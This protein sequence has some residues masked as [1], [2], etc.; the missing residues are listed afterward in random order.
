M[1]QLSKEEQISLLSKLYWDMN[2]DPEDIYKILNTEYEKLSIEVTNLYRRLLKTYDWY[3]LLKLI[4]KNKLLNVLHDD[5]IN[6][7]YPKDLKKRFIYARQFLS[8]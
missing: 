1:K 3:T 7:L 6:H 8:K 5:V 2:V 4:P